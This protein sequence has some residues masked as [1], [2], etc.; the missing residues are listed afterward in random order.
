[1][2]A[3]DYRAMSADQLREE[4]VKLRREQFNLRMQAATGQVPKSDQH[5][6]ARREIARLKTVM[7][8]QAI[9][10]KGPE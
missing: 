1:M 10:G 6:K 8:E 9:S 3:K 2:K 5:R 4:L 7:R